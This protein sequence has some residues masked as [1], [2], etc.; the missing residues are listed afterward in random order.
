MPQRM[1]FFSVFRTLGIVRVFPQ[2][3]ASA[4]VFMFKLH[5]KTLSPT[6]LAPMKR[7]LLGLSASMLLFG[8][9]S[10]TTVTYNL[11]FN[12]SDPQDRQ[13]LT[14]ASQ[15]VIERRLEHLN[16]PILSD[17]I[18]TSKQPTSVTVTMPDKGAAQELTRELA[19]P[20]K[21]RI[22]AQTASG[23]TADITVQ[24]QGGFKE[25]GIT[26]NDIQWVDS[27]TDPSTNK[28]EVGIQLTPAGQRKMQTLFS[29]EVG[30]NIGIFVRDQLVSKLLVSSPDAPSTLIISNIPSPDIAEVFADDM[31]VGLHVTFTP[32][33]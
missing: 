2:P 19:E 5:G 18:D 23:E 6:L 26:E 17:S 1:F 33:P 16:E 22:M 12:V 29:Q 14:V 7:L 3:L 20:F 27:R 25:T 15:R 4:L 13:E 21:V 32:V 30:K 10:Q 24:G 8:C 11:S 31:N 28:G 9:S